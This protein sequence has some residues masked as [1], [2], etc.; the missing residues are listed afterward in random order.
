MADIDQLIAGAGKTNADFGALPGIADSYWSGLDQKQKRLERNVFANGLPTNAD[1]TPDYG[2]A[3]AKLYQIGNIDKANAM[4]A[5]DI[6]RQQLKLGQEMSS[7]LGGIEGGNG[8]GPPVQVPTV[9]PAP[10]SPPSTSRNG[11]VPVA[12]PISQPA[13]PMSQGKPG[14]GDQP[15]SIVGLVSA[16]GVPDELAGPIIQQVSA[17]TKTDP[18]ATVDPNMAPRVQQIVQAA[19]QRM[20]S[21]GQQQGQP[22][23]PMAPQA[24]QQQPMA[25]VAPPPTSNTR[26]A[27][28]TGNDPAIQQR[29]AQYTQI[30]S[31]PALPQSV[32]DAA[33]MRLE[34]LQNN[35]AMTGN[36][37][38]YA[39]AQGQGYKGTFQDFLADTES[40]KTAATE[41]A[42]LG[43]KKYES[44]VEA[45]IA[46]QR[47]I[48]QIEMVQEAMNDPNFYSGTGEKYNLLFKR[49]KSAVGID[50]NA[51]V[52]QE[53]LR[54]VTSSSILGG[55]GS[56]KGLGQ[57]R[58]AEISLVKEASAAPD[59]SVP[60]NKLLV[61]ISKRTHQRNADIAELAQ[62]YKE[63][64]GT[65]DAGFD[66][67]VTAYGKA[68][69]LLSDAEIKDWH[70]AIGEAPKQGQPASNGQPMRFASPNDVH[71]AIAGGRLKRGDKFTDPNGVVRMV[72]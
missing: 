32:R 46:A 61:E 23:P 16:A 52:P 1:G 58:N 55:L 12:P 69:P 3:A 47:E 18:N 13:Q 57:I 29:A 62:N 51:A 31:N 43:A 54:K 5:L 4:G 68:H 33:K 48:P 49:L 41:E 63:Q 67:M 64:N 25:P 27:L 30:M 22:A 26:G 39:Q 37:K 40:R 15:G 50:P 44:L 14:T 56:L 10:S 7:R 8:N 34:A 53:M 17:L 2:A 59:N 24:P 71:A 35:S 72:P 21:G 11:S 28:P 45:G 66:K 36:Q 38:E 70:R 42:K 6:Q 65:L 19:A 20:K 9:G 60:A